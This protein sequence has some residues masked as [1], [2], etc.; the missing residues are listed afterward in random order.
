MPMRLSGLA[1]NMDTDAIIKEL[2]KA[3]GLK[4]TKVE[5]K[6]TKLEWKKDIWKDMNSKIYKF[7]TGPLSKLKT[8]G[9]FSTKKATSSNE[10]KVTVKAGTGASIGSYQIEVERLAS[11]QYV[12]SKKLDSTLTFDGGNKLPDIDVKGNTTLK[13]LGFD[14]EVGKENVIEFKGTTTANLYVTEKTTLNDFVQAAKNAGLNASYD[15]T[16]K[17]LFLSGK[18]S[19]KENTFGVTI[20]TVE[21]TSGRSNL[22][23][24]LGYSSTNGSTRIEMDKAI[25]EYLEYK[26]KTIAPGSAEDMIYQAA[27]KKLKNYMGDKLTSD[28]SAFYYKEGTNPDDTT[29]T[30]GGFYTNST[31]QDIFKDVTLQDLLNQANENVTD[32]KEKILSAGD[33]AKKAEEK[34]E[35]DLAGKVSLE[36]LEEAKKKAREAAIEAESSIR[37]SKKH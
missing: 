1:S 16:Q 10:S 4:K 32:D 37:S 35:T 13:D 7:Y 36:E 2:M 17:R 23:D 31:Y 27:F 26:D 30:L 21:I 9:S 15:E 14:I 34:V 11:A 29:L 22:R 20:K 19:G 18:E 24:I 8:Q 33:A 25:D 5:N 12:T 6:L 28:L 3:Q